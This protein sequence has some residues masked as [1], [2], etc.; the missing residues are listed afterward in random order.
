MVRQWRLLQLVSRPDG[1][2]IADAAQELDCSVR[3]IWRDLEALQ[4][5]GFPIYDERAGD[6][7]RGVW[8]VE[9][10]FQRRL[11]F[12]V[13]L[14]EVVAF[15]LASKFVAA[16]G[17]G[18]LGP[19]LT[20]FVDK[21][22]SLLAPRALA[23]LDRM[24]A[25]V[26]LRA[27]GAKLLLPAA[28]HLPLIQRA[29]HE[30]RA[31]HVLYYS[32]SRGAE[33]ERRIDPYY[34]TSFAGGLYLVAYCHL[35][36][37]VRIFALER[38]RALETLDDRFE[39]PADFDVETYLRDAWGIVRGTLVV[40]K[41]LFSPAVAPYVRERLRHPSQAFRDLP[42]GRLELTL[43]VADTVE[44]RRWLLGFGADADVLEPSSLREA[45]RHEAERLVSVLAGPSD[46]AAHAEAPAVSVRKPPVR[47]AGP[48]EP[49]PR[50]G[51]VRKP[52][53]RVASASRSA[54]GA[55][56]SRAAPRASQRAVGIGRD[57][58]VA[59][60]VPGARP[61]PARAV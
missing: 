48:P 13:T 9:S 25:G 17:A 1:L 6:G 24:A 28:E 53:D 43:Q 50:V 12:P 23:L 3:T 58:A 44:V 39:I 16:A 57:G 45:L 52:A 27:L 49:P 10:S 2:T 51:S 61:R 26:G 37:A 14:D 30:H 4:A 5:S 32:M 7:R 36:Q 31:L 19:A 8:R 33:S 41:V 20:S 47:V 35:R 15:V 34:L 56:M 29:L 54:P 60:R 21:V 18:V 55:R 38:I 40:V 42:G 46:S 59:K 22:R 11:P